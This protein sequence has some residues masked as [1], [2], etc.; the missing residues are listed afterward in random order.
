MQP[1]LRIRYQGVVPSSKLSEAVEQHSRALSPFLGAI[2]DWQIGLQRWHQHHQQGAHYRVEIE[3]VLAHKSIKLSRESALGAP[4]EALDAL[5]EAIFAGVERS[6]QTLGR[7]ADTGRHLL[8][9]SP[10]ERRKHGLHA[11]P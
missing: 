5:I 8:A 4:R 1:S 7:D 11:A 3:V 2:V 10:E 9:H 6:L